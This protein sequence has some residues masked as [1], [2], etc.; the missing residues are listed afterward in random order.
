MYMRKQKCRKRSIPTHSERLNPPIIIAKMGLKR[1]KKRS[2]SVHFCPKMPKFAK[3]T[4]HVRSVVSG[5]RQNTRFLYI[6]RS[7]SVQ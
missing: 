3:K 6:N 2:I 4:E 1:A 5:L 7:I